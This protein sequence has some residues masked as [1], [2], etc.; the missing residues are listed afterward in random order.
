M[1]RL[2]GEFSSQG[3]LAWILRVARVGGLAKF[4]QSSLV[5]LF[6][7]PRP[8]EKVLGL[9]F[10]HFHGAE[11]RKTGRKQEKGSGY[12]HRSGSNRQCHSR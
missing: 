4:Q 8:Q 3:Q 9:A 5:P 2:S 7:G 10:S 12:R 1:D 6:F 11:R